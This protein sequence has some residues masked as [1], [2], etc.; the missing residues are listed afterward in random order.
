[1]YCR[2]CGQQ[3]EDM[4]SFCTHCGAGKGTG[5]AY[6]PNCG[7]AVDPN[8]VVCVKCGVA[9]NNMGGQFNPGY[10]P[11]PQPGPGP[12]NGYNPNAAYPG[13]PLKSK[14]GSR[15]AGHLPRRFWRTQL[16]SR[17]RRQ[18]RCADYR[19]AGNLRRRLALGLYRGNPYSYWKYRPGCRW[20]SAGRLTQKRRGDAPSFFS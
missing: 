12:Q 13:R 10:Q 16:L 5:N 4:A 1:M 9:L 17:L 19:D 7:N 15:P 8:A 18:G 20:Q 2:N 6:C 3:M 14:L 11:G